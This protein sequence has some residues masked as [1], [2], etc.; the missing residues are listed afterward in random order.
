MYMPPYCT[1]EGY[2]VY[3]PPYCTQ[4]VYPGVYMPPYCTQEVYHGV[5]M[6]PYCTQK[7]YPG[8]YASLPYPFHCWP[9]TEPMCPPSLSEPL[10][11]VHILL[12]SLLFSLVLTGFDSFDRFGANRRPYGGASRPL[13]P[14]SL[15]DSC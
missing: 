4:E 15:L 11:T 3:M 7:G 5:Y 10:R 9:V 13:R 2:P 14:V 6:L 1:R 12:F 8:V